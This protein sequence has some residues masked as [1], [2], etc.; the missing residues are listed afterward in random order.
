MSEMQTYIYKIQ[1][2]REGFKA[3]PTPEESAAMSAHW[4]YLEAKHAA[5][6]LILA[7]PCTD[8]AFGIVIF[9]AASE[10]E[11]RAFMENDPSVQAEVMGAELHPF[12]VSLIA[13]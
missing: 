8:T 11:A 4:E 3:G 7:G 2:R 12:R 10:A 13:K 5:G 6:E 1:A 9:L